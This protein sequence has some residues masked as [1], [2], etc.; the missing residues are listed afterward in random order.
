MLWLIANDAI[1]G[2]ALAAFIIDNNEHI[3]RWIARAL[4]VSEDRA[5][6]DEDEFL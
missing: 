4:K 2:S 6:N 5:A 1:I 3:S